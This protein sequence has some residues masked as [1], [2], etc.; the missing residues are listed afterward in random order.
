MHSEMSEFHKGDKKPPNTLDTIALRNQQDSPLLRL[1]AELRN[2]IYAYV[3]DYTTAKMILHKKPV[4]KIQFKHDDSGLLLACRQLHYEVQP[5]INTCQ[6]MT[7]CGYLR[8]LRLLGWV[9]DIGKAR[10][11][12]IVVSA[13]QDWKRDHELGVLGG[14]FLRSP[15]LRYIEIH[16]KFSW[17]GQEGAM[18]YLERGLARMQ[19]NLRPMPVKYTRSILTLSDFRYPLTQETFEVCIKCKEGKAVWIYKGGDD[20]FVSSWEPYNT[21]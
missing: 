13:S 12:E 21:V 7:W 3:S 20:G 17:T 4:D 15:S 11:Q 18:D 6:Y 14:V 2:K 16:R 9:L 5:Y 1:P 8:E 19:K 10:V